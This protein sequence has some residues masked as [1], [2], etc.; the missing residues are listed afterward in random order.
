MTVMF[1]RLLRL[2]GVRSPSEQVPL[3]DGE[4]A[5]WTALS[6]AVTEGLA[7][8]IRKASARRAELAATGMTGEQILATM[9][10]EQASDP[11]FHKMLAY[12]EG[13][14]RLSFWTLYEDDEENVA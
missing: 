12:S 6:T 11:E 1:K 8:G 2:L 7:T 10:Q 9:L 14:A 13:V 4:W 5:R 3:G